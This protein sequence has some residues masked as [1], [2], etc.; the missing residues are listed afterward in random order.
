MRFKL[1]FAFL[2]LLITSSITVA[3]PNTSALPVSSLAEPASHD[4]AGI[5][6]FIF[7]VWQQAS[8][9]KIDG[10][11]SDWGGVPV[12][13]HET[14]NQEDPS[15]AISKV[16]IA[17]M[18]DA[19]LVMVQTVG[20]PSHDSG[21]FWLDID[22][23]GDKNYDIR[24]ALNGNGPSHARIFNGRQVG[25]EYLTLNGVEVVIKDVVEARIPYSAI[26]SVVPS[27]MSSDNR[28]LGDKP[29][30]RIKPFTWDIAAKKIVDD[31]PAIASYQLTP[32]EYS[33]DST[34]PAHDAPPIAID[35]PLDGKWF[36]GQ[37]AFGHS[38]HMNKWAYDFMRV[39]DALSFTG[40]RDGTH[41][42][43]YLDWRQPVYS[44]QDAQV[45][46]SHSDAPDITAGQLP[47]KGSFTPANLVE[48]YLGGDV[49]LELAHFSQNTVSVQ[50][51]DHVAKGQVI[52][53]V[54]NAGYSAGP[55]LHIAFWSISN[56]VTLPLALKDVSV[57][58]NF[59]P[60]DPWVRS[61]ASWE[62]CEGYF[63]EQQAAAAK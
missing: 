26:N 44:P 13:S 21:A 31:G 48:L 19:L 58:L 42:E 16:A 41:N 18:Q 50:R 4:D 14:V 6:N 23:I 35:L 46:N 38:T 56:K 40:G 52:G 62:P 33:L 49:R 53:L 25:K 57:S 8:K 59:D 60:N 61:L 30:V 1:P 51:R 37:G 29:W 27:E 2:L 17:P 36:I 10:N 20:K 45:I 22:Y 47:P 34:L 39:D 28:T 15:R 3:A 54:G 63:V 7:Q 12:F 5:K 24:I 9:I 43:N 11:S 55:H 32:E